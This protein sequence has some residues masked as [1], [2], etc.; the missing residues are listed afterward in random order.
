M[1]PINL[2]I[3]IIAAAEL[4]VEY[5]DNPQIRYV[6]KPLPI[7]LL[8]YSL[9]DKPTKMEKFTAYG[10]SFSVVGDV[11]L[12][13]KGH[14]YF[15]AGTGFFLVAH[16]FYVVAFQF[17]NASAINQK[18]QAPSLGLYLC[19]GI[20]CI[21]AALSMM[22]SWNMV[23][24][25]WLIIPYAVVLTAMVCCA[26]LRKDKTTSASFKCAILGSVLFMASDNILATLKF[27]NYKTVWG[28]IIVMAT[29]YLGQFFITMGAHR[30]EPVIHHHSS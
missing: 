13:I 5:A 8:I 11:L 24:D 26:I 14:N 23:S 27:H 15:L 19:C 3:L 25:K 6:V 18:T 10:L 7:L 22:N 4:F 16:I 12:S 28:Q 29:Y 20:I 30:H 9:R 2:V 17:P 1:N 21:V